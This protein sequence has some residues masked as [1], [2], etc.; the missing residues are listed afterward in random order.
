MVE[1]IYEFLD[2]DLHTPPPEDANLVNIMTKDVHFL[3]HL[4]RKRLVTPEKE[5]RRRVLKAHAKAIQER[6]KSVKFS[7]DAQPAREGEAGRDVAQLE[8]VPVVDSLGQV[9]CRDDL[10]RASIRRVLSI[11]AD[12]DKLVRLLARAGFCHKNGEPI[13]N[14]RYMHCTQSETNEAVRKMLFGLCDYLRAAGNRQRVV[15][16]LSNVLRHSLAKMFAAKFK[17]TSRRKVFKRGGKSLAGWIKAGKPPIGKV[18]DVDES[19]LPRE[20]RDVLAAIPFV[21]GSQVPK[22]DVSHLPN[23]WEPR[24]IQDL[25]SRVCRPV[26]GEST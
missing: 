1:D 24:L 23:D 4:L 8:H 26:G 3:G 13:P 9:L 15:H 2:K 10:I 14:F 6:W 17:L 11:D 16:Y 20:G 5:E 12:I 21:R 18:D 25:K 22:P 19:R 7:A